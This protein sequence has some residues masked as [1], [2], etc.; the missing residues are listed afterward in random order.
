MPVKPN[1]ALGE[2]I[3]QRFSTSLPLFLCNDRVSVKLE[4]KPYLQPF[5]EI[6][7]MREL[8]AI[9]EDGL[10]I[11][12]QF[13]L[14]VV[15]SGIPVDVLRSKLTYWQRIGIENLQPTLQTA[16]EFTQNGTSS[17][18]RKELHNAR[19]LRYGPHDLHE[20]RGKFFPQLVRSLIN[21][22]KVSDNSLIL[23]PM[24]GSGTTPCEAVALG[25]S[26]IAADLNPLSV[27]I[28]TVK[29]RIVSE[30][31]E[32]FLRKVNK[33][34][35][36]FDFSCSDDITSIWDAED[37]DYLSRWF[38]CQ[39]LKEV[40]CILLQLR[41]VRNSLH[42]SFYTVCLSNIIRSISWQ[43]KDDLRVRK[44][45]VKFTKGSAISS[46]VN[47]VNQQSDR[48][49][50]YLNAFP[51]ERCSPGIDIRHG[52]AVQISELFPEKKGG[53]DL[54]IT[55]P[56][57]ATALPYL[58]T[59]RLSLIAI[60]LLPRKMHRSFE[61]NMVGT[62]EV[63]E[64]QRSLAW[65]IYQQRRNEL[66]NCIQKL[67]DGLANRNHM[68][69]V[70]FR[71]RN[72]PALL[73]KYYLNMLDAMRS[74]YAMM[75]PNSHA[76]YVVGNNSTTS[77]GDKIEIPTDTFL[78]EMGGLA[79]WQLIEML[80]MELLVSRDIFRGNRG[81]AETILCFRKA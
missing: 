20:Y 8:R 81:S 11:E 30:N 43:K 55:S 14:H 69:G 68:D 53:V 65:A 17:F 15:K 57:Y 3:R 2:N 60:G 58:D 9:V 54:L 64:R 27:L 16:L 44:E 78:F 52:N 76:Y 71:R 77:D 24:C 73:G 62:R 29:S 28:A 35:S 48:I 22:S 59:D 49:Y 31:G 25:H 23:D 37:Y 45:I 26:T 1:P 5:E 39:A 10:E 18:E 32:H 40:G 50:H 42:K 13:G 61:E 66:P 21:I 38:D 33:D 67:I 80:P 46:F 63:S 72:L 41:K 34:L 36:R 56:P 47:E 4:I 12:E 79:G 7:A 6:L 74:A 51:K 75:A 19:R 70:G